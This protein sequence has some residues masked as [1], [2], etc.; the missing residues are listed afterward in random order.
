[1]G[2][3]L[4]FYSYIMFNT[5]ESADNSLHI[6]EMLD[7]VAEKLQSIED[8]EFIDKDG[9]DVSINQYDIEFKDV[10][11][12]YDSRA[13]LR[14]ISFRIPQN[15]K[16]AIE[17]P[18]GSGTTTNCSLLA[19]VYAARNGEIQVRGHTCGELTGGSIL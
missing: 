11:F 18:S 1:M 16:T 10:S 14:H 17:G 5:I 7:T 9:K 19:R 12:G 13:V 15:T 8:A 6:L 3:M 4:I 2:I